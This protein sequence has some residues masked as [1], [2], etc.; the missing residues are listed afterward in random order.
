MIGIEYSGAMNQSKIDNNMPLLWTFQ[1]D[2]DPKYTS[3]LVKEW[4]ETNQIKVM[5][6]PAQSPD[7]NPI[8][9]LWYQAELSLKQKGPFKNADE[10]YKAIE[11][12]WNE[13]TQEKINKLVESMPR[14]CSLIL[15]SKGYAINY[16][17]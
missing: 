11:T 15:K 12:T 13:I 16:W 17:Y 8:E 2:N 14:R 7:L 4:S 9:N 5:K 6:W 1:Q 3:K 10:L